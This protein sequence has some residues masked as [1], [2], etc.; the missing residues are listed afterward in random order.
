MKIYTYECVVK[1][2]YTLSTFWQKALA[3][4]QAWM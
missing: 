1:Y 3:Y 4:I 2:V